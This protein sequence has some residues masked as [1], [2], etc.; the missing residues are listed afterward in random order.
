M[1]VISVNVGLPREIG[2]RGLNVHTS[3]FKRPVDGSVM[4]RRLNLDGDQQ[5]DLMVHGGA[6]KAVYA[7]PSE[8][9]KLWQKELPGVAFS[10]RH[11][12]ENLTTRGLREDTLHIGDRLRVGS[13]V[14]TVTQPRMPCYKLGL[15]FERD[16]MVERFLV[17]RRSGF[18]FSVEKEGEIEAGSEIELVE[19]NPERV[20]IADVLNLYL[21]TERSPELI[22]RALRVDALPEG[23]KE[24]LIAKLQRL[25]HKT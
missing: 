3:I 16:D 7:Y 10:W 20:S 24:E 4:V 17:S 18:Y 14:L 19:S 9:Y 1:E 13:A 23:W 25:E 15:R 11:F 21:G 22:E 5:S 12:G 2:W 6:A 8:H